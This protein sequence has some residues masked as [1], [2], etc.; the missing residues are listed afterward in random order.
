LTFDHCTFCSNHAPIGAGLYCQSATTL[1][2]LIV[3]FNQDAEGIASDVPQT[4]TCCDL[5]GNQ[6]GDYV[7]L[8]ADQAGINGNIS[9]DPLFCDAANF[10]F[11]LD[12]DSPCLDLPC[13]QMGAWPTGCPITEVASG[14][15]SLESV[16]VWPNPCAGACRILL[17]G[18]SAAGEAAIVDASGRL[19]RRLG[20][21]PVTGGERVFSWDGRDEDGDEVPAGLFFVRVAGNGTTAARRLLVIR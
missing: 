18:R 15:P 2:H 21:G 1:D 6:G 19:V 7:G 14:A 13:V 20:G 12:F 16:R 5:F 11:T 8:I 4:L 3:A 9:A 17:G 10:N